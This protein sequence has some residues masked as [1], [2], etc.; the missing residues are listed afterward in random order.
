MT[1]E[2]ELFKEASSLYLDLSE[3]T[4]Q[5]AKEASAAQDYMLLTAPMALCF[6]A[7]CCLCDP[8]A[9]HGLRPQSNTQEESTMQIQAVEGLKTVSNSIKDFSEQISQRP[10]NSLEIDRVSL[11]IMDA[12]YAGAANFAWVVRE[13]GDEESQNA[14]DGIRHCLRRLSGRWRSVQEYL[15]VLEAQEFQYAVGSG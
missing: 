4:R 13:S 9:C 14:L 15:R 8:Y 1:P 6:S 5:L 12:I 2:T 7:L 3:L 10:T 11:F